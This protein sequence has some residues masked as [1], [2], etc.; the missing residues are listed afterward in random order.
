MREW[1]NLLTEADDRTVLQKLREMILGPTTL[2]TERN[3][4]L[5]KYVTILQKTSKQPAVDDEIV[6][7]FIRM[8]NTIPKKRLE[9]LDALTALFSNDVNLDSSKEPQIVVFNVSL[10]K[11][12]SVSDYHEFDQIQYTLRKYISKDISV[13]EVTEIRGLYYGAIF[14]G[15]YEQSENTIKSLLK[16]AKNE[17][18]F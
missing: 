14:V 8:I 7:S 3:V 10:P 13:R 18:S 15:K 17:S 16:N 1:I 2:S 11:L 9:N 4:A 6:Q 12:I 5:L